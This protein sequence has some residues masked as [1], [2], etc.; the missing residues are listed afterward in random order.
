MNLIHKINIYHIFYISGILA[1]LMLLLIKDIF[2]ILLSVPILMF[3]YIKLIKRSNNDSE[4]IFKKGDAVLSI[5]DRAIYV[6]PELSGRE[7]L[8]VKKCLSFCM[9]LHA[10]HPDVFIGS[11]EINSEQYNIV[12]AMLENEPSLRGLIKENT[13]IN[14]Y[15]FAVLQSDFK[16]NSQR[17][18]F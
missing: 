16:R 1:L 7:Q 18:I 3:I 14:K 5:E 11:E 8:H 12:S 4:L 9:I 15:N 2:I 13:L 10:R 17:T 6:N